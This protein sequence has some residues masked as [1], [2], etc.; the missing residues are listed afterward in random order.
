MFLEPKDLDLNKAPIIWTQFVIIVIVIY[1]LF[2]LITEIL[3]V[4]LC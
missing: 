4:F 3:Y 2:S 1:F